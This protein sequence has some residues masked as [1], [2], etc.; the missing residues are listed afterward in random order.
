MYIFTDFVTAQEY[1]WEGASVCFAIDSFS[2]MVPLFTLQSIQQL[3]YNEKLLKALLES[4]INS[5]ERG[6]LFYSTENT[7]KNY[8]RL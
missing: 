8:L 6:K 3:N 4:L 1:I 5:N 7:L 2:G